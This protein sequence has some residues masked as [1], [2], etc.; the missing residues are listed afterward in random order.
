MIEI[1]REQVFVH[2][3]GQ[4]LLTQAKRTAAKL[5]PYFQTSLL[6][7][8]EVCVTNK[9]KFLKNQQT[10]FFEFIQCLPRGNDG[11]DLS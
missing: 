4:R 11:R 3:Q 6:M 10:R 5:R 2:R 1:G 9:G 7:M 8:H